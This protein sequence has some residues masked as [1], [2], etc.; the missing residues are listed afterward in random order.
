MIRPMQV[1]TDKTGDFQQ[2][3]ISIINFKDIGKY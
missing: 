1:S 3:Q 2:I